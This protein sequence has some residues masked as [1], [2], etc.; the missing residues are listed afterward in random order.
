MK[1]STLPTFIALGTHLVPCSRSSFS[2]SSR[3]AFADSP[4][5]ILPATVWIVIMGAIFGYYF[6]LIGKVCNITKSAT[7]REAWEDTMG[8]NGAVAIATI[9]MIKPSLGNLAYSMI[10]ADT[11]QS[12]CDTVGLEISRMH[13]LLLVTIVAILP[14]CLMKNLDALAPFSILGTIG[15]VLTVTAMA[16]R[17]FD[18]SYDLARDG[19][20]VGD[21]S[22]DRQ[23]QFGTYSGPWSGG[24]LVFITMVYEAFVAHYNA[25]RFLAELKHPTLSRYRLVVGSSFGASSVVYIT[26]TAF[27]FLTFGGNCNGYILNNYSTNDPLA[28]FCRVA[29]AFSVLFTYPIVFVGFR[30]GV[31]DVLEL[32]HRMQ[33]ANNLN[34]LTVVLLTVIT[35]LAAMCRDLGFINA[36][37][38]GTLATAIVF[39][40][41]TLMF[42][43]VMQDKREPI[44][45]GEEREVQ[46]ALGLMVVGVTMGLIGVWVEL[47]QQ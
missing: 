15:I 35:A 31:L 41:P 27:G 22:Q 30:D 16:T 9:N 13:S 3:A 1:M 6:Q 21:L 17:Y 19:R 18:G 38:G 37:G 20:F 39:V 14:L 10:L 36:V 12:L 45:P 29:I 42:R 28:T 7:Y 46:I 43:K 25:P 47:Q 24:I 32:P 33:T 40:F 2:S 4:D 5:A 11:F 26:M 23:P 34:V 8:E 44:T